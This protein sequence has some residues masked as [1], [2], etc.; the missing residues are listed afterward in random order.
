MRAPERAPPAA[1]G[2]RSQGGGK[3]LRAKPGCGA[4]QRPRGRAAGEAGAVTRICGISQTSGRGRK[5]TQ[6]SKS[7]VNGGNRGPSDG[8]CAHVCLSVWTA[9]KLVMGTRQEQIFFRVGGGVPAALLA[10]ETVHVLFCLGRRNC[11][12]GRLEHGAFILP[13]SGG[14]RPPRGG[15]AWLPPRPLPASPCVQIPSSSKDTSHLE[16]GPR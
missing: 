6:I 5:R 3:L 7:A 14:R 9:R 4:A 10:L 12:P 13:P 11:A 2:G 15:R 8:V 16:H 1:Q